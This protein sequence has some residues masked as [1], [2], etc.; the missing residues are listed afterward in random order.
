MLLGINLKDKMSTLK[1]NIKENADLFA[2]SKGMF[3]MDI[4]LSDKS[5]NKFNIEL[6]MKILIVRINNSLNKNPKLNI[7]NSTTEP[8][9]KFISK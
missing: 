2:I 5:K 4:D 1:V 7:L 9:E 3:F 6:I 8:L